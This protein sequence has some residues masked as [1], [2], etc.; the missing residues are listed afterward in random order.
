[1]PGPSRE[2]MPRHGPTEAPLPPHPART[3]SFSSF[4]FYDPNRWLA[5]SS[6]IISIPGKGNHTA[7]Y[8]VVLW[9]VLS[10]AYELVLPKTSETEQK[11]IAYMVWFFT[12]LKLFL[13]I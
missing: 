5:G 1:V 2:G 12:T 10:Q 3:Y 11:L 8:R 7:K 6:L 13:A 9:N 4:S